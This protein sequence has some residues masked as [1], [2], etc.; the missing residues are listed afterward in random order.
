M[1]GGCD[2][3]NMLV[4]H[5]ECVGGGDDGP[6]LSEQYQTVRSDVAISKS[7]LLQIDV[8]GQDCGKYN[9]GDASFFAN[10]GALVE[11]MNKAEYKSGEKAKPRNLFAHN[12][13]QTHAQTIEPQAT[14]ATGI[15]GKI[16]DALTHYMPDGQKKRV[17]TYR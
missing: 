12:S 4:P 17:N 2:S 13:Q 8:E 10:I 7:E 9:D 3:F 15:L 16:K 1:P 5:S 11:P 6:D 14:A